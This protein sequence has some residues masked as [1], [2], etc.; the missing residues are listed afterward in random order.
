MQSFN[1][2]DVIDIIDEINFNNPDYSHI[3]SQFYEELL[4]KLGKESGIAGEFYTPRPVVRLM[5]KIVDPN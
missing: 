4:I 5:T 1:L 2:K 3:L